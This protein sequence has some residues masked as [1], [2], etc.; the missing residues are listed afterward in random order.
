MLAQTKAN[1]KLVKLSTL[2]IIFYSNF[3]YNIALF[4]NLIYLIICKWRGVNCIY[5]K[6]Q[7]LFL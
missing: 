2:P 1:A 7:P 6:I 3:T 5:F 4:F